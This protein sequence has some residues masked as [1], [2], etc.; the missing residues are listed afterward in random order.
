VSELTPCALGQ[1]GS[2]PY[3]VEYTDEFFE[4]WQA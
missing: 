4:W 1:G 3:E 2:M